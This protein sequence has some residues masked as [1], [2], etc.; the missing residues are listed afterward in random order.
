MP[1]NFSWVRIVLL[2]LW[3][4]VLLVCLV[5]FL[6]TGKSIHELFVYCRELIL[7]SGHKAVIVFILLSW[8]RGFLFIP[9]WVFL[10]MAG[11]TFGLWYGGI[12]MYIADLGSAVLE[13]AFI[14]YVARDFLGVHKRPI[15]AKYNQ[16]LRKKGIAT[17]IFLR[18]IPVFHFDV[19]NFAF[20]V[21][22]VK[23]RDYFWGTLVGIIPGIVAYVL[24]G[25]GVE[26][27]SYA[28]TGLALIIL[29]A[30][31]GWRYGKK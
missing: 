30:V 22:A 21:S 13:F 29:L 10:T 3:I 5:W 12:I 20:G 15:L 27:L 24:L 16:H 17:V 8:V 14:R 7:H 18:L 23:W 28:L 11:L 9:S 4:I 19:L 1:K 2:S 26:Q 25:A 6:H 31:F